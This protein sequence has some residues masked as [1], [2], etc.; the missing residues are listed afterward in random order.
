M[1]FIVTA[2][3]T[4]AGA[5]V[6]DITTWLP[7]FKVSAESD[8]ELMQYFFKTPLLE[9]I[10]HGG[11]WMVIGRKGTGKSAIYEYLRN[12]APVDAGGYRTIA[13]SFKDYP[14]PI[15]RLY[16]E[17]ME[18]PISSYQRSWHYLII[19]KALG[20]LIRNYPKTEALPQELKAASALLKALYGS[21]DP[22]LLEIIKAKLFRL[23]SI[24]LPGAELDELSLTA[25]GIEFEDVAG[26]EE[27]QRTLR[28][29]AFHLLDYFSSVYTKFSGRYKQ[30]VIIDQ[31]DEHW[32]ADQVDEYSRILVNLI[33]CAQRLN[34]DSKGALKVIVFLR[35]DIYET[36]RFND[37]NK[38]FQDSAVEMKWDTDSLDSMLLE[39]ID[40]YAPASAGLN[41]SE[42]SA[43]IFE[44]KTVRHGATPL[45]HMLRRS[46][47]RPRDLIVYLNKIREVHKPVANGLYTSKD[48]YGAE[49]LVSASM[50]DELIDEWVAQKPLF[51]K[52][53]MTLQ[54]IGYEIFS[55]AQYAEKYR[56]LIPS[57]DDAEVNEVLRFLFANSIIG[58]KL[59]VNWE[60]VCTNPHMQID[61]GHPFHVNNGLKYRLV[62]TENREA[63]AKRQP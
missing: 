38:V 22:G 37:K 52:Y 48:L 12:A 36:L 8:D 6:S 19:V 28:S 45:K 31:L 27:L 62:L 42:R 39:R 7:E 20:S 53:L 24:S 55:R 14:W 41:R 5:Q 49:R 33:L 3:Y 11:R 15:H 9:R 61:F 29:N 2:A 60:Y 10:L 17:A 50:Y 32:L 63:R 4:R 30:A 18:S 26:A 40:R 46:F 59:S 16:R 51:E 56:V 58:Q 1:P 57:A 43:A 25:G 13:L 21:P 47:Y 35:A 54:N 44:N 23:K 34:H